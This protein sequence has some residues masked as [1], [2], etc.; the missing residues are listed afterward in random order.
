MKKSHLTLKIFFLIV[1]NDLIDTVA[2]L[3][4]KKGLAHTGIDSINLG[5]IVEFVSKSASSPFLWL[6]IFIFALN[7]FVWIVILYKVDLSVAM[8]VG[9]FCY[10]FIPVCALLFLHESISL[11]R[12]AGIICI[13]LGIHFVSQ[14]KKTPVVEPQVNG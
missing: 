14:S 7:F 8:P 6:G 3:F 9:S 10:I 12:W 5:N 2:Q 1:L 13:V 4:M 11:L